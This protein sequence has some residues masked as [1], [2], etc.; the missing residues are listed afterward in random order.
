[1]AG[2]GEGRREPRIRPR[3]TSARQR[4]VLIASLGHKLPKSQKPPAS[5]QQQLVQLLDQVYQL[6]QRRGIGGVDMRRQL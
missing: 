4:I 6:S 5:V 1:M 2:Q 3:Q